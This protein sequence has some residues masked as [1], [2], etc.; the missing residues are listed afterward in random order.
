MDDETQALLMSLSAQREHVLGTLDGLSE[1]ALRR[2]LL[3]SGWTPLGMVQ[4]LTLEVEQFW[5]RGAVA[6]EPLTITL[7]SGDEAWRVPAE[8]PGAEIIARYRDEIARADAIIAATPI[9]AMPKWWPDFFTDFP[10]RPLRRT[11]LHVI[12]ETATHAGHLDVFR[13]LTDGTQWVV[14]TE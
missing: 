3:P 1:D 10:A 2:P 14:L 12:A 9:D 8:V 7:T 4:H 6:G 5:F 11:I 13:E